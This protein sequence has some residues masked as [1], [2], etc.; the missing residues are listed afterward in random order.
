MTFTYPNETQYIYPVPSSGGGGG[1]S[2][3]VEYRTLTAGEVTA[4][5][6]SLVDTPATPGDVVFGVEGGG[7]QVQP[8]DFVVSGT[9]LSWSGLS[10]D[11]I[12]TAGD[13]VYILYTV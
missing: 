8:T 12:L 9:T 6:L 10:L 3:E 1:A 5:S 11:G 4:G 13:R 2:V 7:V